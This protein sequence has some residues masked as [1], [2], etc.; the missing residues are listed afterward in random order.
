MYNRKIKLIRALL[1]HERMSSAE[2]MDKLDIS[3]RTLRNEVKEINE[4]LRQ[5]NVGIYSSNTG[6][7]Y[8]KAEEKQNV[9]K[10]LDRMIRKS[11]NVILPETPD[12]RFY[13]DLPLCFLKSARFLYNGQ[14]KNYLYLKQ[15]CCRPRKKYRMHADGTM[16]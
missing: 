11:K 1:G 2:L 13:L 12:E 4:I 6:G 9:Q 3:Q 15:Q 10:V 7:Y 8:L 14:Q 16:D 5:E